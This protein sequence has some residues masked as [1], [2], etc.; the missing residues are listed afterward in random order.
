MI[1]L[2]GKM[3]SWKLVLLGSLFTPIFT[4]IQKYL[5]NDWEFLNWIFI[6]IILDTFTGTWRAFNDKEL[7]SRNFAQV[8]K[9]V[10]IYCVFLIV[11][12]V[13][14][15]FTVKSEINAVFGWID[16]LA[17]STLIVREAISVFENLAAIA[18]NMFPIKIL[19]RLKKFNEDGTRKS[20]DNNLSE[21]QL[22][23]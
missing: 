9:K 7:S 14:E 1:K 16:T 12:H 15:F 23:Q 13:L 17:Y 18:P 6:L 5:F 2:I 3:F 22:P 20:N 10:I 19:E 11:I 8:I 4:Y 21:E